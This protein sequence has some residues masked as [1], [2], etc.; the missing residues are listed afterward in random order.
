MSIF[1]VGF[2]LGGGVLVRFF[3]L[4]FTVSL[5]FEVRCNFSSLMKIYLLLECKTSWTNTLHEKRCGGVDRQPRG[6]Q[7]R[8]LYF[9]TFLFLCWIV[10]VLSMILVFPLCFLCW[11]STL[12]AVESKGKKVKGFHRIPNGE[13]QFQWMGNNTLTSSE[14]EKWPRRP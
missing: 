1:V 9:L 12:W 11:K 7:R 13:I 5:F 2:F 10:E 3:G 4:R 6:M 14:E 8:V